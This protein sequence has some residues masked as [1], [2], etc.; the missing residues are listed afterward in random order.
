MPQGGRAT[1]IDKN[2]GRLPWSIIWLRQRV[3][4]MVRLPARLPVD[5]WQ[6]WGVELLRLGA[7]LCLSSMADAS[8]R[9]RVFTVGTRTPGRR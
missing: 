4:H 2:T 5:P 7:V 8:P 6:A 1:G 3:A 9:E